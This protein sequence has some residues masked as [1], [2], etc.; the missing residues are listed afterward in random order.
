MNIKLVSNFKFTVTS[1]HYAP[2]GELRIELSSEAG[3]GG[4][5]YQYKASLGGGTEELPSISLAGYIREYTEKSP[6]KEKS[7]DPYRQMVKFLER[8]GD[9]TIDKVTT[10]YLQGFITFLQAA[11][12]STN[13]V[14][15]YFQKL[16]C[17]LHSAYREGLFDDRILLRV[18]RVRRPKERKCFLTETELRRMAR[19]RRHGSHETVESMFLFSC[20]T[21]LRFGDITR[22]RWKDV[23]REGKHLCLEF[24]QQKTGTRETLPL[25][26]GAEELLRGLERRGERVFGPVTNQHANKVLKQWIKDS[27][28]RKP[29]TFHTGRHTFCVLL[30]TNEVPIFTV[31]QLMCHSDISTTKVY[32]DTLNRTKYKAVRRLPILEP[33]KK[34]V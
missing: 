9:R 23:K 8:Y 30:L 26:E 12:L 4:S 31:Q 24:L 5:L 28:V 29:A 21:G 13:T 33:G 34:A 25:C 16:T 27:G 19:G 10:E 11:G 7:K 2:D 3:G 1:I 6:I 15:L 18:Q 14:R 22:L 17:V 32:A 20:L